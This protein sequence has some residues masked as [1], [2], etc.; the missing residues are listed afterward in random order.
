MEKQPYRVRE[1]VDRINGA[2]VPMNRIVHLT[3]AEALFDRSIGRIV[4]ALKPR[5]RRKR[6]NG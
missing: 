1:G 2:R 6:G 3:A 5:R 4:P